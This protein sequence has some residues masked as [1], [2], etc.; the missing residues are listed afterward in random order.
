MREEMKQL[1]NDYEDLCCQHKTIAKQKETAEV[2]HVRTSQIVHFIVKW[3]IKCQKNQ[4]ALNARFLNILLCLIFCRIKCLLGDS[5]IIAA[6][7]AY[8]SAFSLQQKIKIRKSIVLFLN[9]FNCFR[10][11]H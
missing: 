4:E 1:E 5:I 7:V 11:I 10:L 3:S 9:S 8:L 2:S 6:S